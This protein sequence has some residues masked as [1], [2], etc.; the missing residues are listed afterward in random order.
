MQNLLSILSLWHGVSFLGKDSIGL[1]SLICAEASASPVASACCYS[2]LKDAFVFSVI[3][4]IRKLVQVERQILSADIV[5]CPD[6][7]PLEQAPKRIEI[8]CVYFSMHIFA[9]GMMYFL[10]AIAE[11]AEV[12]IA[13]PFICGDQIHLVTDCL[14]DEPIQRVLVRAFDDSAHYVA[15]AG[16]CLDNTSLSAATCDMALLV[17]MAVLI[18]AA[19]KGFIYFHDAHK[20]LEV[21]IHHASP[22]PVAHIPRGLMGSADLPRDLERTDALLAVEHLPEHFKP[23]LK[24]NVSILEDGADRDGET[25]GRPLGGRACLADPMPR[26]RLELIHLGIGAARALH[27]IGPAALHQ[28]LLASVVI[29]EGL[30]KLFECHH[31]R[32]NIRELLWCQVLLYRPIEHVV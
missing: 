23:R 6:D 20:F 12:V 10:V 22:K 19:D 27:T 14:S 32:K 9:S 7:A 3:E 11:S 13:L 1:V 28:E 2:P 8:V 16:D 21:T 25:I 15:L 29:R 18:L 17:P 24:V 26:A 4:P 30:H 5:V 31:A